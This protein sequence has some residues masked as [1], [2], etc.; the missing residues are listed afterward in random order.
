[1]KN[2]PTGSMSDQDFRTYVERM[3]D[4]IITDL[5]NVLTQGG[6]MVT[7][8]ANLDSTGD[9]QDTAVAAIFKAIRYCN[10]KSGALAKQ[11]GTPQAITIGTSIIF[12]YDGRFKTAAISK[13]AFTATDH[14]VA[15]SKAACFIVSVNSAGTAA[16]KK[17]ADCASVALAVAAIPTVPV[18][19]V[20][21]GYLTIL[22][23]ATTLFDATTTTLGATGL[24]VAF[25]NTFIITQRFTQPTAPSATSATGTTVT[26]TT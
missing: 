25:V 20:P 4:S 24:T 21:V 8:L 22:C 14:D 9:T 17:S 5:G 10:L 23:S 16:I 13:F 19:E 26:T 18:T 2:V 15:V 7:S 6:Y 1:M 11:A 3:F 12:I